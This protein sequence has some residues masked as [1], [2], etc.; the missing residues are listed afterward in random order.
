MLRVSIRVRTLRPRDAARHRATRPDCERRCP[1]SAPFLYLPHASESGRR[2]FRR[3]STGEKIR[4][5]ASISFA[6]APRQ[7]R[8]VVIVRDD[9]L[10]DDCEV[11]PAAIAYRESLAIALVPRDVT[12]EFGIIRR[13]L[14]T[15]QRTCRS[16]NH[17]LGQGHA[18]MGGSL[19]DLPS[20]VS[21]KE[22][23]QY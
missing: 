20:H 9:L 23:L 11:C 14:L 10:V 15:S 4:F 5:T 1:E 22:L 19:L 16:S 3:R 21:W 17:E 13:S 18:T 2:A 7:S 12:L 8:A 6:H